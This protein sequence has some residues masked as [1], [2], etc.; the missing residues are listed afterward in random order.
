MQLSYSTNMSAKIAGQI[1][2]IGPRVVKSYVADEE[3]EFGYGVCQGAT[4]GSAKLPDAD[5]EAFLGFV[6]HKHTEQSYPFTGSS[7]KY[8]ANDIMNIVTQ[9]TIVVPT[10]G[11]VTKGAAVYIVATTGQVT[12]TAANNIATGAK[13]NETLT[14]AGL[15]EIEVNNP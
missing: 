14:A 12:A 11:A 8:V 15:A 7:G 4:P 13:F 3:I 1:Q 9:G 5:T 10:A 6:G 2:G